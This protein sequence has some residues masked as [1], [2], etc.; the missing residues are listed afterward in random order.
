MILF[1]EFVWNENIYSNF[2]RYI[3]L[4]Y[5]Q[6]PNARSLFILTLSK[7]KERISTISSSKLFVFLGF[8]PSYSADQ[9]MEAL[10]KKI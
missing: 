7:R 1:E 10:F 5:R 4:V 9:T 6:E 3:Q 2:W 8:L